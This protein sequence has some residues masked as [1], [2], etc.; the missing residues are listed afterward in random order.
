VSTNRLEAFSDGV[1]AIAI[2]LLVLDIKVPPPAQTSSL[3]RALGELW[4]NYAPD[5][6]SFLTIGIIWINHH[7]MIRRLREV[8][9]SVLMHNLGLL[10][11]IGVLPFSTS[12]PPSTPARCW[13]WAAPS[14]PPSAGS[15][16]VDPGLLRE[17]IGE[18]ER[19]L[20]YRRNRAGL[21]PYVIALALAPI[22]AYATLILCAATA[23]FFALPRTTSV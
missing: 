8:D 13:R 2:T 5:V 7:A 1:I 21:L 11:T 18:A 22:S 16:S 20:I 9:H 14:S 12:P 10:L 17:G 4:P 23:V 15:C 3:A 19:A 6:V